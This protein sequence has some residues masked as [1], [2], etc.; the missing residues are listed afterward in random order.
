MVASEWFWKCS[1]L[2]FI[3]EKFE[4]VTLVEFPCEAISF[5]TF[6]CWEFYCFYFVRLVL[7]GFFCL[8]LQIQV[9]N[10]DLSVQIIYFFLIQSWTHYEY[11]MALPSDLQSFCWKISWS[12]YGGSLVYDSLFFSCSFQNPEFNHCHLNYVLVWVCLGSSC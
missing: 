2:I 11:I 7:M 3:L 6:V 12:L 8:F 10:S 4:K 5:W 1:I 9:T